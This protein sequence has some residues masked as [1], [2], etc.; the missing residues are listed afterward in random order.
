MAG[1]KFLKF[2]S[3]LVLRLHNYQ[4][5]Y[6]IIPWSENNPCL[7]V[8]VSAHCRMSCWVTSM[9]KLLLFWF[10]CIICQYFL[11]PCYQY[12]LSLDSRS[13]HEFPWPHTPFLIFAHKGDILDALFVHILLSYIFLS[14]FSQG[15]CLIALLRIMM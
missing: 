12:I 4:L 15:S 7:L 13:C 5:L 11:L 14:N 9:Q 3:T 1:L 2:S 10:F 6:S 8:K